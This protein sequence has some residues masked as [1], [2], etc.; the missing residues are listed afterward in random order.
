MQKEKI[1]LVMTEMV[2]KR[3]LQ[4]VRKDLTSVFSMIA[5]K[6]RLGYLALL[7]TSS[8][9]HRGKLTVP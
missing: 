9:F 1:G 7:K 3:G 4:R 2:K 5:Y 8:I 6:F